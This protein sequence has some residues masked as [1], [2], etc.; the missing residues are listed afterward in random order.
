[1]GRM[2]GILGVIR[3]PFLLLPFTLVAAGA[4]AARRDGCFSW[5]NTLVALA[6]LV[7]LHA[8]VN[9]LNEISDYRTGIDFQTH[10]TP[11]SGGSGTLPEGRLAPGTA[12]LVGMIT[13][14]I[15][16]ACGLHFI[17]L[18]GLSFVPF[19]AMGAALV[20]LYSGVFTRA[21]LG[22]VAAGLGLGALSVLGS[23][24]VQCGEISSLA[25]ST[26][27][28]AFF[29]TFDLL[30]LNEF[31]DEEADRAGERKNL[32]LLAGRSRA[33]LVYAAAALAV[34]SWILLAAAAGWLP[35]WTILA[36]VPSVLLAAPLRW[37]LRDPSAEVPVPALAANVAWNLLTNIALAVTLLLA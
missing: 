36:A 16:A 5:A 35:F 33:S 29:M 21:G 7:A 23:A 22:E 32:V 31:P 4:A 2:T 9:V 25:A 13:T 28:P 18:Y 37:A 10:R 19:V 12:S 30:L 3:A 27:V 34:P 11:F 20:L 17:V 6:G 14:A 1:M 26:S 8:A 24:F 15:G